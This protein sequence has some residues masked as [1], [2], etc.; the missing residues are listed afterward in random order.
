MRVASPRQFPCV[1]VRTVSTRA[2]ARKGKIDLS[3]CL[4]TERRQAPN[5]EIFLKKAVRAIEGGVSCIQLRDSTEDLQISLKSALRLKERLAGTAPLIINNRV[6]V[7]LAVKAEGVHLGQRDFPVAEARRLLGMRS[8]IGLT[9]ETLEDVER[10]ENL[11]VDY[12]GVQLFP[13][14][15]TKPNSQFLWGLEGLKKIKAL[16]RHRILTIGG[17]DLNNLP[18]I[19]SV[20]DLTKHQDGVAMV[21]A[22]WRA[23]DPYFMA[24]AIRA[25]LNTQ[26]RGLA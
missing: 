18:S 26:E 10:A 19:A 4:V 9:V 14:K 21:G 2:F 12:L 22:L 24:K 16:S 20:I 13:S 23:D 3:F 25:S 17:I 1:P 15:N 8:I 11:D 7:A 6:D 5:D